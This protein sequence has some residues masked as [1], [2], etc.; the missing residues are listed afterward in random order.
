MADYRDDKNGTDAGDL[1]SWIVTIILL[2]SPVWPVGL[3]MLFRKLTGASRGRRQPRH[4]YDIQRESGAPAPGTQGMP[5]TGSTRR[6]TPPAGGRSAHY[7][8]ARQGK[9][10]NLDRG[11]GL[12]IGG[13]VVSAIFGIAL[14]SALPPVLLEDGIA[15]FA[16]LSPVIGFFCGG[17]G[18]LYAGTQR[19]KK[20]KR[21]RKYLAL[22]GRRESIF[23]II[24]KDHGRE[25]KR[26]TGSCSG[27]P[28][29]RNFCWTTAFMRNIWW[30]R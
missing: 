17:L 23:V 10:V 7:G 4:P 6:Q 27:M 24:I 1:I 5:G 22:I 13:A 11:K 16:Y 29:N 20:A 19:T 2:V 18:M 12:T 9:P 30:T 25:L 26:R 14:I 15:A 8:S 3:I 21:F 28:R